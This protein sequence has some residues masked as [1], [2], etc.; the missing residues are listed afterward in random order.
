MDYANQLRAAIGETEATV[1]RADKAHR[2]AF[3]APSDALVLQY[4]GYGYANRGAPV[5]LANA[6]REYGGVVGVYFHELFAW[7]PPWTSSFWLSP[8]QR[9][10]ARRLAR[11]ADFWM[12]NSDVSAVWLRRFAA[13]KPHAVL[14]VCSN[15]G[16]SERRPSVR[17]PRIVVFGRAGLR[18]ATYR[19]S[20]D[21]LFGWAREQSLEVHDVGPLITDGEIAKTLRKN[22][23]VQH[24]ELKAD[25]V[26]RMLEDSA[27]GAVAY[28]VTTVAKSGVF[29]AYCAHGVCP[30]LISRGYSVASGLESPAP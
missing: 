19:A 11:R 6:V 26:S 13:G 10:V 22:G 3:G 18:I 8:L 17:A 15:V 29:A 21:Y 28:P 16:E 1:L 30:V 25:Q 2:E 20:A 7:G 14:P 9:R 12:T 27:F 23:A 24:G 4:S 5:W